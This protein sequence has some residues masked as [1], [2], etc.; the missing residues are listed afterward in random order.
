MEHYVERASRL[1]PANLTVL[2]DLGRAQGL[3][4]DYAAA[5]RSLEKAVRIAPRKAEALAEAGRRCQEFG[6]YE[7]AAGYFGRASEEKGASAEVLLT[8][9]EL[10]ERGHRTAEAFALV[11]RALALRRTTRRHCSRGRG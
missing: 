10:Y 3:R 5:E 11:E 2:F 6:H 8:L 1:D 4:Y 9:A 7:M